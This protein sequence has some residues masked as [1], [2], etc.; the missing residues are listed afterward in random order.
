MVD[1]FGQITEEV[2]EGVSRETG[3]VGLKEDQSLDRN[4]FREDDIS[5]QVKFEGLEDDVQ[6]FVSLGLNLI[7]KLYLTNRISEE[8]YF[9]YRTVLRFLP[10]FHGELL[11]L[12][13]RSRKE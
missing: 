6:Y 10:Q 9:K 2:L 8:L 7:E 4:T 12:W 3:L 5:I 13:E 1:R 11:T